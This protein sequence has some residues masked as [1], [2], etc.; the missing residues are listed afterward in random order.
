M[1]HARPTSGSAG[2]V[3]RAFVIS[4][5]LAA[6]LSCSHPNGGN[7]DGGNGSCASGDIDC[8]LSSLVVQQG[9]AEVPLQTIASAQL[10]PSGSAAARPFVWAV[11]QAPGAPFKSLIAGWDG[12]RWTEYPNPAP[13]IGFKAVWTFSTDDAWV[14]GTNDTVLH[15]DGR[16]WSVVAFPAGSGVDSVDAIVGLWGDSAH[17]LWAVTANGKATHFTGT[18]SPFVPVATKASLSAVWGFGAND[19]WAV[20]RDSTGTAGTAYHY[21]GTGWTASYPGT[22]LRLTGIWGDASADV[23][24]AAGSGNSGS[25]AIFHWRGA[26][27]SA[28][29][30]PA[31]WSGPYESLSLSG[32]GPNDVWQCGYNIAGAIVAHNDGTGWSVEPPFPG[33]TS[34]QCGGLWAAAK[35]DCWMVSADLRHWDGT[36]W[37]FVAGP[38]GTYSAVRGATPNSVAAGPP[39]FTSQPPPMTFTGTALVSETLKWADPSGCRPAFCFS[40]CNAALK[41]SGSARCSPSVRDGLKIG[42]VILSLGY[43]AVPADGS[44]D[45]TLD[46]T[47][48]SSPD[49]QDPLASLAAGSAG[50]LVGASVAIKQTLTPPKVP[51]TGGSLVGT[52]KAMSTTTSGAATTKATTTYTFRSDGSDTYSSI[53]STTYTDGTPSGASPLCTAA[54]TYSTSGNSLTI[55]TPIVPA[56]CGVIL[57]PYTTTYS[58]SGSTLRFGGDPETYFKQ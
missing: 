31:S 58:V 18:W 46:V 55:T 57:S 2:L 29:P 51:G 41:C 36:K 39:S 38:A 33:G 6:P 50:P 10:S 3:L 42:S 30:A 9:G 16:A 7:G 32:T 8:L 4:L 37:V 49:C 25:N 22:S 26:N 1:L 52:W 23:W 13:S 17:N 19:V 45:F 47:P 27:W 43:T 20:G 21:N 24:A 40:V 11:G 12:T 34:L 44:A 15:W 53:S 28:D 54:G 14:A 56:D 48:V 35:N 5:C